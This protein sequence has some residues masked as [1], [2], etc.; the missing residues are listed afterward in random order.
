MSPGIRRG[1]AYFEGTFDF[2]EGR[3][4]LENSLSFIA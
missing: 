2:K 4:F 3:L 1:T